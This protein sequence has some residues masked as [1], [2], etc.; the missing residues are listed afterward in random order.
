MILDITVHCSALVCHYHY[1]SITIHGISFCA[2]IYLVLKTPFD[3]QTS[4]LE[5][6]SE[7]VST[8]SFVS[9]SITLFSFH[10]II[11]NLHLNTFDPIHKALQFHSPNPIKSQI[12]TPPRNTKPKWGK[13]HNPIISTNTLSGWISKWLTRMIRNHLALCRV[14]SNHTSV[15]CFYDISGLSSLGRAR[16]C[17]WIIFERRC[18]NYLEAPCSIHGARSLNFWRK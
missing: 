11:H 12:N 4:T 14:C 3:N 2:G 6:H 18:K 8:L 17:N 1:M 13:I 15:V 16:D 5:R 7:V 9:F 10:F